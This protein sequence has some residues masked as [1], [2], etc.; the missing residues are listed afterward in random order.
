M[1]QKKQ[2]TKTELAKLMGYLDGRICRYTVC[3]WSDRVMENLSQAMGDW[4]DDECRLVYLKA[5]HS[6]NGDCH[7]AC[8]I[9][10]VLGGKK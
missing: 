4:W 9:A 5:M 6:T 10:A 3:H 2:R 8:D 1:K 7:I